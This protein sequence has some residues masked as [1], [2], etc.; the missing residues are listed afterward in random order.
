M[1]PMW[2]A[3]TD[4][5][6]TLAGATSVPVS[7]EMRTLFLALIQSQTT[8]IS[9]PV[10]IARQILSILEAAPRTAASQPMPVSPAALR[11]AEALL[12]NPGDDRSVAELAAS[13]HA[14]PRTIERAFRAETGMTL[15]AWRIRN[16]VDAACTL[17]RSSS[18]VEAVAHRVGYTTSSAFRRVF[19]EHTGLAP[20]DYIARFRTEG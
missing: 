6:T 17:L 5:A 16:R 3:V 4:V 13:V 19:K 1:L 8:I 12:F 18:T 11:I 14:S 20:G 10:N 15:R 2:F 7:A 9:P